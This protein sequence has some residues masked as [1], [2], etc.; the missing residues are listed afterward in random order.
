[1][2]NTKNVLTTGIVLAIALF[3][4]TQISAM[5]RTINP[6]LTLDEIGKLEQKNKQLKREIV[7]AT[8]EMKKVFRKEI[9]KNEK[10]LY[11][12]ESYTMDQIMGTV[13]IN[14]KK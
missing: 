14:R 6:N 12:N 1:M 11:G 4:S 2:K 5:E 3:T 13:R 9:E 7:D 10:M 8:P